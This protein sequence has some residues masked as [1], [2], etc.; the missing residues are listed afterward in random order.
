[1]HINTKGDPKGV[2][3]LGALFFFM[4]FFTP[5]DVSFKVLEIIEEF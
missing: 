3:A 1:M 2:R 4:V 5:L